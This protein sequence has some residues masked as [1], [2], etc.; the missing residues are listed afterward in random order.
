MFHITFENGSGDYDKEH[1]ML[2]FS[3]IKNLIN[4]TS[5]TETELPIQKEEFDKIYYYYKSTIFGVDKRTVDFL[6]CVD[7]TILKEHYDVMQMAKE[8]M[9]D[10]NTEQDIP[11]VM[12]LAQI[13]YNTERFGC[14]LEIYER[15]ISN[16]HLD[17]DILCKATNIYDEVINENPLFVGIQFKSV[18]VWQI[19]VENA[20]KYD[21]TLDDFGFNGDDLDNY[22][23]QLMLYRNINLYQKMEEIGRDVREHLAYVYA[24]E[25]F[26]MKYIHEA[27]RLFESVICD[28]VV[29]EVN[30][31]GSMSR[32][33]YIY[34]D[35]KLSTSTESKRGI[36]LY[37][38]LVEK[39]DCDATN[40]L[41]VCYVK[42]DCVEKNMQLGKRL[43][44]MAAS[45]GSVEA[46]QN[47]KHLVKISYWKL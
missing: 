46:V 45:H 16:G 26:G 25:S 28:S 21:T 44:Q 34:T 2:F 3:T 15:L 35:P 12:K 14:A 19:L 7:E 30:K 47:L 22:Y 4:D 23:E 41:A 31:E 6:G 37:T 27:K 18:Y 13:C 11:K 32:L 36:K 24:S 33:A 29:A 40:S 5:A 20:K 42:G 17:Y 39:N 9:N 10:E 8:L 1:L 43:F 38:L